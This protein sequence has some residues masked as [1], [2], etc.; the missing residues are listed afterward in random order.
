[1]KLDKAAE[2][3]IASVQAIHHNSETKTYERAPKKD[4]DPQG[5]ES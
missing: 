1:M 4:S 2:S 3:G 5:K